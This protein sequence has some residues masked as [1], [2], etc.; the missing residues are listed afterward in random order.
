MPAAFLLQATRCGAVDAVGVIGVCLMSFAVLLNSL[1][2]HTWPGGHPIL[3]ERRPLIEPVRSKRSIEREAA[4]EH[5]PLTS[6]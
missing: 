5:T 6:G 4:T 1:W 2:P 3:D